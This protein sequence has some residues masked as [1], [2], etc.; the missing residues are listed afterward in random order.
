MSRVLGMDNFINVV[1]PIPLE[2][3]F[4]YSVTAEEAKKVKPGMRV[5]VPFGRTRIYTALLI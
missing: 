2:R 1:L 4:T 5:A 3:L